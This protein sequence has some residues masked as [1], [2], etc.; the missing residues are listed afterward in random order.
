M[1]FSSTNHLKENDA[2]AKLSNCTYFIQLFVIAFV[3]FF[4]L[5]IVLYI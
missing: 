4:S 1:I 5:T 2:T 3:L